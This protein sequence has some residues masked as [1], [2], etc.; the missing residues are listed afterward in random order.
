MQG[1]KL[2]F[3]AR[4]RLAPKF[5][6][7]VA[8]ANKVGAIKKKF[9]LYSSVKWKGFPSFE[10]KCLLHRKGHF[11]SQYTTQH[12][13]NPRWRML[14]CSIHSIRDDFRPYRS[15]RFIYFKASFSGQKHQGK[16]YKTQRILVVNLAT[17]F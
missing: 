16:I 5:F 11:T 13:E 7:V 3:L 17:N 10:V 8:K 6:K 12:L 2:T 9:A 15:R 14:T 4:S 1:T